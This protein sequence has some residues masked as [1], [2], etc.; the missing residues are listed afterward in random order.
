M[1]P[2]ELGKIKKN[3]LR[4][5]ILNGQR[6]DLHKL[7]VD[8]YGE[9]VYHGSVVAAAEIISDDIG[10]KVKQNTIRKIRE[11]T[12]MHNQPKSIEGDKSANE[13]TISRVTKEPDQAENSKEF[14]KKMEYLKNWKPIEPSESEKEVRVSGLR[15]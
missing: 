2:Q 1:N 15:F 11:K 4:N 6:K 7:I 3:Q 9:V 12:S 5:M 10:A 14:D 13:L 8:V